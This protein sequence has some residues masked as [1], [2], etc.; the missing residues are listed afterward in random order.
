VQGEN[1][2]KVEE[3]KEKKVHWSIAKKKIVMNPIWGRMKKRSPSNGQNNQL[4]HWWLLV[5]FGPQTIPN[6][7]QSLH[8]SCY[9][10]HFLH[11]ITFLIPL[12]KC[13]T[14]YCIPNC[15]IR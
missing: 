4:V 14:S 9:H 13:C 7:K 1:G 6:H 2:R 8:W 5:H 10:W 11:A 3:N 12:H 15:S